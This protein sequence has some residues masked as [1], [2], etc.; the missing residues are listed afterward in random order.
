MVMTP[1]NPLFN[2]N[3]HAV[4]AFMANNKDGDAITFFAPKSIGI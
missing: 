2:A 4:N 1:D 3:F